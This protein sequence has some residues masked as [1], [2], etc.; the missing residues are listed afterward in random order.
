MQKD[1][2]ENQKDMILFLIEEGVFFSLQDEV[3]TSLC[4]QNILILTPFL[5][6]QPLF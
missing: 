5:S 4:F 2:D 1:L 6:S 3:S